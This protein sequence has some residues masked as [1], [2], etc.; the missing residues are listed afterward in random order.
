MFKVRQYGCKLVEQRYRF[1][2]RF[3][4]ML[5]SKVKTYHGWT[6]AGALPFNP[7]LFA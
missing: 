1:V 7:F 6:E 5:P 2:H 4:G 3:T